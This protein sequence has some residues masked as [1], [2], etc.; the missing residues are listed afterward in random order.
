MSVSAAKHEHRIDYQIT[1]SP[2]ISWN[3]NQRG[4]LW[5]NAFAA[6]ILLAGMQMMVISLFSAQLLLI[7]RQSDALPTV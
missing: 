6:A 5:A 3:L 4:L 1:S 7:I 2:L